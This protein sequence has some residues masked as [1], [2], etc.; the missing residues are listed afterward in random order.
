MM[1]DSRHLTLIN[2]CPAMIILRMLTFLNLGRSILPVGSGFLRLIKC[3]SRFFCLFAERDDF[4][5]NAPTNLPA[6][7]RGRSNCQEG[8]G[9]DTPR[10]LVD[11]EAGWGVGIKK[12]GVTPSLL[13]PAQQSDCE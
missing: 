1:P 12:R 10:R 5:G 8:T 7:H 2:I 6:V 13:I 4:S 9:T 11:G 3:V